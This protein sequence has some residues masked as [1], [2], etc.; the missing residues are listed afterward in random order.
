MGLSKAI[1]CQLDRFFIAIRLK[2]NSTCFDIDNPSLKDAVLDNKKGRGKR[3]NKK[4]EREI[5][6]LIDTINEFLETNSNSGDYKNYVAN[7]YKKQGYT[8][9]EYSKDKKKDSSELNLVL[10]RGYNILLVQCRDDNS[11]IAIDDIKRFQTTSFQF[12]V[13]NRIFENYNVKLRYTMAGLF[14]EENAYEYI[15]S[16]WEKIDYDI[17]KINK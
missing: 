7:I 6:K 1:K 9:W 2:K 17:I 11:N 8:V 10:K 4:E 5:N 12:L 13:K 14:L 16:N 15:K 3:I